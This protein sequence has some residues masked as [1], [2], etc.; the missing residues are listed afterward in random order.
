MRAIT[1]RAATWDALAAGHSLQE[2]RRSPY[3]HVYLWLAPDTQ[4]M[5]EAARGP[6]EGWDEAIMRWMEEERD[7]RQKRGAA[8]DRR[9]P[10]RTGRARSPAGD[11][12]ARRKAQT[13]RAMAEAGGSPRA[14][15]A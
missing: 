10:D 11:A 13:G 2:P 9:H 7:E 5:L 12:A 4:K 14:G 15:R 3:G 6:S 8:V 1:I